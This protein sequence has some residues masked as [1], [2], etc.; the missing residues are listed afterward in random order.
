[1]TKKLIIALD[2]LSKDEAKTLVEKICSQSSLSL[3]RIIFKVNDLI[4]LVGF[5][6]LKDIFHDKRAFI[7]LD[8]KY[9][10]IGN[11]VSNY[12]KALKKSGLDK[13]VE[14]FTIHASNSFD[15]LR[16]LVKTRDDLGLNHIKFLAITLLTSLDSSDSFGVYYDTPKNTVL[17]LAHIAQKSGIDGVVCS[18]LES[19]MI[20]EVFGENFLIVNPGIRFES[21]NSGDQKRVATSKDAINFGANHIVMG[22]SILGSDDITNAIKKAID[23]MDEGNYK[24]TNDFEFEKILTTGS[25]QEILEYIGVV[26]SRREGGKYCRLTSSLISDTYINIGVLERYPSVL[27]KISLDLREKLI[28]SKLFDENKADDYV[29]MGSQMGSVRISAILSFALGIMQ[30]SIYSEKG[31]AD[32]K[33]MLLKRHYINLKGKKVILSEDI[34]NVGSTIEKMVELVKA[35]GGEVVAITC[36]GNRY[37]KEDFNGIPLIYCFLPPKFNLYY[38]DETLIEAR[39]DYPKIPDGVIISKKPKNERNELILSMRK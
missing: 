16:N 15:C 1:M 23:E 7:M 39:K 26:Y 36:V 4:S 20:R 12:L 32:D 27:K 25:W 13:Q 21:E 31:G 6:G 28:N 22:R 9:Y 19:Q 18:A 11:T 3:D 8:G 38:D 10:D 37:G 5:E 14:L 29:V 34:V 30:N 35:Q 24:K 33:E 17:N 2:N